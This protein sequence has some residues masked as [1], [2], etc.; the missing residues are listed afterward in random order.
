MNAELS[1]ALQLTEAPP[2]GQGGITK[3]LRHLRVNYAAAKRCSWGPAEGKKSQQRWMTNAVLI[4]E[5]RGWREE[6]RGQTE[7]DEREEMLTQPHSHEAS[8]KVE[9]KGDQQGE[10][11]TLTIFL[12]VGGLKI[13]LQANVMLR[14]GRWAV[15]VLRRDQHALW[16]PRRITTLRVNRHDEGACLRSP[17]AATNAV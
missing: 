4:R 2:A 16:P 5:D 11:L 6:K 9:V 10:R 14:G 7:G 12:G 8:S 15:S 1:S 13:T 17:A 3:T